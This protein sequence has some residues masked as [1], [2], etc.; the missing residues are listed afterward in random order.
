MHRVSNPRDFEPARDFYFNSAAFAVPG[1]YDL[2]N[3]ARV[4]DW[5]RGWTRKSEAV[6]LGKRTKI[7]ER[8]STLLRADMENPFN[9]VRWNN[10]V[11]DRSNANFGRVTGAQAGRQIQLS[12]SL[13]F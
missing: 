8:A 9:F 6:S 1:S 11:A 13:E 4:L 5:A 7:T 3:T 10:P 2:G 12:L